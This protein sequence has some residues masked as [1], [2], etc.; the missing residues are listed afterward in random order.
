MHALSS[1]SNLRFAPPVAETHIS[2]T[3][4]RS[5]LAAIGH[6]LTEAI[7]FVATAGQRAHDV[8]IRAQNVV[9]LGGALQRCIAQDARRRQGRSVV[10][11]RAR[12]SPLEKVCVLTGRDLALQRDNALVLELQ[13][14]MHII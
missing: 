14:R 11:G 4:D 6:V 1:N 10:H 13:K 9:G 8:A 3:P 2:N 12:L 5:P 7:P